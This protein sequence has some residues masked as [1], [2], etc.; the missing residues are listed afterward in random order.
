MRICHTL[1]WFYAVIRPIYC[2][3][4]A[5]DVSVRV[6]V[7]GVFENEGCSAYGL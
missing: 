5:E 4:S 3:L 2:G 1:G 7:V 6:R